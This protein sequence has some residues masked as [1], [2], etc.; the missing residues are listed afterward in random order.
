[1]GFLVNTGVNKFIS[2]RPY[3]LE[4]QVVLSKSDYGFLFHDSYLDCT[5]IYAFEDTELVI[6]IGQVNDKTKTEIKTIVSKARTIAP[7]YRNLIL[8]S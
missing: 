5:Q 6:G 7:H 4:C 8:S 2:Q 3:L 1:M